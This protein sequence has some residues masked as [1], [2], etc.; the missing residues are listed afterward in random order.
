MQQTGQKLTSEDVQLPAQSSTLYSKRRTLLVSAILA[1]GAGLAASLLA[2]VLMGILRLVAGIPTPVELF[3]DFVLKHIDVGTFIRLLVTFSPN[4]KT[5]PLGLALLGMI[6]LGTVLALLYAALVRVELPARGYRPARREWLTAL[7][8]TVAMTLIATILFWEELRQNFFGLTIE[9]STVVTILG[10]LAVFAVYGVAL[11]LLYRALLPKQS[12]PTEKATAQGRRLLLSR[13]GVAALSV[14]AAAGSVGLI[15]GYLSDYA[16]YDG[17]KTAT[18]NNITSPITPNNEHYV[19]TQNT[20]DPNPDS[21]LWRLEVTGLVKNPGV[22]TFEEVQK[23]PSVS[24]PVTLECI[25]NGLG[26]HLI[27]T[28]IWQGVT[29]RTL[30]EQHGGALPEASYVAFYSVDGYTISLPLNEVLAADALLAWR[31][32][33]VELPRRHGFPMRVLIPGRYGEENPKWLTRVELTDHFVGGLYSDQGWYHGMLHTMS[34]IDRP[35]GRVALGQ[36]VEIGGIAFAGDR[37]IQKVEISVDGGL[38][39]Q[40]AKLEPALSQDSWVL[41]TLQWRPMLPGTYIIASRAT[42]GTGTVQTSVAQSTVPNG[43]TGYHK[44]KVQVV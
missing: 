22:Y 25:A 12:A 13:A 10:L 5:A 14:G 24:R 33:G 4:S 36:T 37:G 43:A 16:S 23:L 38:T 30:L 7:G 1:P 34:R 27:G 9:W 18:H 21:N 28:A 17:M 6:A 26:D 3:G 2:V 41:W 35:R 31:M 42:D 20:V 8:F 19:V 32:N 44:V 11:C 40:V 29:L 39:W 15:R